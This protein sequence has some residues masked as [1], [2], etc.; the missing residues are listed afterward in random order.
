MGGGLG[1]AQG[2][3]DEMVFRAM[4]R[5]DAHFYDPLG[6]ESRGVPGRLSGRGE[7]VSLWHTLRDLACLYATHRKSSSPGPAATKAANATTPTSFEHV[8]GLPLQQ[9]WQDWITFEHEFQRAQSRRG[10]Q[11]PDHAGPQAGGSPLGSVSRMYYD[12]ATGTLY[13]GF[14]NPG[15]VEHVG[16]LEHPR[17]Q[18]P[19]P[20]GHQA[21]RCTI[22][23]RRLRTT[24]PPVRPST[25]MTTRSLRDLV[26]V[27]VKTGDKRMLIKH[28]R[29][30]EIVFN[31]VDQSLIGVRHANGFATLVRIPRPTTRGTGCTR[32]RTASCRTISTFRPTGDC[33]R[34]PWARSTATSSCE[35]G[36]SQKVLAGTSSRSPSTGSGSR[37]R[38]ASCSPLTAVISTAAATTPA[39]PT[40]SAT[41]SRRARSKRSRTRKPDSS[42]PCRSP[43]VSSSC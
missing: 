29:I 28:A 19:A 25:P 12:E 18:H 37:F 40:S 34:R 20:D 4:V 32:F 21:A 15:A 42:A 10:A 6:L 33:C 27:D 16:A 17:R 2:G 31:P 1:R 39:C 26:E 14:R 41:K 3:Y 23:S 13:G 43:T 5:D 7:R 36:K 11:V 24:R 8:F 35:C 22:W 30:G 38:R 9:A